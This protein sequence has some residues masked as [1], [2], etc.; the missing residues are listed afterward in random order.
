MF[1]ELWSLDK[2]VTKVSNRIAKVQL[3]THCHPIYNA[4][5]VFFSTVQYSLR[6]V[7]P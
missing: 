7:V 2:K 5:A 4:V 1:T 3:L 6:Y